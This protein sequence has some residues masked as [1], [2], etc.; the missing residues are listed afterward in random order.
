[1]PAGVGGLGDLENSAGVCN[2]LTLGKQL[3]SGYELADLLGC[4]ASSCHG[5]VPGPVWPDEVSHSQWTDFWGL[6]TTSIATNALEL[7]V[8]HSAIKVHS[9]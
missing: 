4:V 3:G 8:K 6:R 7:W 9:G 2:S 5:G 1:M